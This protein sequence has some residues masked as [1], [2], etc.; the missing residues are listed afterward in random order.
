MRWRWEWERPF[1]KLP[2]ALLRVYDRVSDKASRGGEGL[3]GLGRRRRFV[4]VLTVG[5]AGG[6]EAVLAVG[7]AEGS[8]AEEREQDTLEEAAAV[9]AMDASAAALGADALGLGLVRHR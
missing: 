3:V 7:A 9:G 1:G 8:A 6:E 2:S 5:T 4:T